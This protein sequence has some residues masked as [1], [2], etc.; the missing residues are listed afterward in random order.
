MPRYFTH[1]EAEAM[2]PRVEPI[3]RE[4]QRL[5]AAIADS[6]AV[7]AELQVKAMSNGHSHAGEIQHAQ[8]ESG[9]ALEAIR[10]AIASINAL[11][12]EVKDLDMG[13]IDF[14]A[15]RHRRPVYLCWRLGEE[16][17]GWWHTLD[18]GLAGRRPIAEF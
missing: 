3:L 4:I 10:D 5:R 7:L 15:Q 8:T 2:L 6:E 1:E 14:L 12:I 17:I 11:D 18:S 16:G 13:L 9:A